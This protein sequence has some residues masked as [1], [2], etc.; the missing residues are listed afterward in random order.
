MQSLTNSFEVSTLKVTEGRAQRRVHDA[1][2]YESIGEM[3][4]RVMGDLAP[5]LLFDWSLDE[6]KAAAGAAAP[7]VF[8]V[9]GGHTSPAKFELQEL[10]CLRFVLSG[11]RTVVLINSEHVR[12]H[13]KFTVP[14]GSSEVGAVEAWANLADEAAIKAFTGGGG[15]IWTATTGPGDCLFVPVGFVCM[16]K[17]QSTA[18][19]VGLRIGV[20]GKDD[21]PIWEH[22]RADVRRKH[23]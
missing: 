8:I 22:F 17:V 18:D 16:H 19:H 15:Q 6:T 10:G 20:V 11:S 14:E 12:A 13:D 2:V 4:T 21:G 23:P 7:S 1:Q 3:A 5:K 9:A